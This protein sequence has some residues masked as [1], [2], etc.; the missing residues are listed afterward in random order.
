VLETFKIMMIEIDDI[1]RVN[2]N[3]SQ[4]CL[5]EEARVMHIP[6][7]TGE[8]WNFLNLR[9]N[10]THYVSEGCTVTLLE[11]CPK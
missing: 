1:V 9:T 11:K 8:S 7:A 2:F 4:F 10:E 5:C 3:N 6:H